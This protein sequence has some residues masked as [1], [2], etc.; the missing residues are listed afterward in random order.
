[1][2]NRSVSITM[3]AVVAVLST[4]SQASAQSATQAPASASGAGQSAAINAAAALADKDA[5]ALARTKRAQ[6]KSTPTSEG[7]GIEVKI[8]YRAPVRRE[9]PPRVRDAR[10]PVQPGENQQNA[11]EPTSQAAGQPSRQRPATQTVQQQASPPP[12][13]QAHPTTSSAAAANGA[14][15][16]DASAASA[17]R[18]SWPVVI[19]TGGHVA[20]QAGSNEPNLHTWSQAEIDQAKAH[21]TAT[22]KGVDVAMLPEDPIKQGECGSPVLFKVTSVGRAP[23]VELSP[24]VLLTCDM[25][26]SLD[27]W[28]KREVQPQ[29]R[30]HLGGSVIKIE[31]MSSYSCRNAYGRTKSRLSEHGKA[32]AIDIAAFATSKDATTVL[33]SWGPTLREQRLIAAKQEAERAAAAASSAN[34][35]RGPGTPTAVASPPSSATG[36]MPNIPGVIIAIPGSNQPAGLPSMGYAPSRLG[37]PKQPEQQKAGGGDTVARQRF[38]REIHGSACKYFGTVLGPEANNAH[39]NHFHLDMAARPRGNFCE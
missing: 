2:G 11:V 15:A 20:G 37:G 21:C 5:A 16:S 34:P 17:G 13:V 4:V 24:P 1:M 32:N 9:V 28:I 10:R 7:S 18:K 35:A 33:A 8:E 29:A 19:G 26:A 27:R 31:T 22:L 23:A 25:I 6:Q 3:A 39:K 38:L 36:A 14:A 30:A 12:A